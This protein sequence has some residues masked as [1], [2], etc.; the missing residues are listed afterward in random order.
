MIRIKT[1]NFVNAVKNHKESKIRIAVLADSSTTTL[2]KI[3]KGETDL[4]LSV[5]DKLAG[6]LGLDVVVEFKEKTKELGG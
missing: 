1:E 5:V 6:F 3:L 2:N 4:K